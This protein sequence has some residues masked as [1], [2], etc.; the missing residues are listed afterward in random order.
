MFELI[1]RL[2]FFPVTTGIVLGIILTIFGPY[3][4]YYDVKTNIRLLDQVYIEAYNKHY[5]FQNKELHE[6][7]DRRLKELI[8]NGVIK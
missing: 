2:I 1:G 4:F 5:V 7:Y 3:G 8:K 6:Q